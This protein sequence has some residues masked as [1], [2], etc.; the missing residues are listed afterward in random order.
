MST[1]NDAVDPNP[2]SQQ[3]NTV[4]HAF[5]NPDAS[6]ITLRTSDNFDFH[7]YKIIL[8]L[9]SPVFKDMFTLPQSQIA[10][11]D[12][13]ADGQAIIPLSEDSQTT[14]RFLKFCYP[15]VDPEL[16]TLEEVQSTLEMM[17]KYDVGDVKG[18]LVKILMSPKFVEKQPVRVFAIAYR[19]GL[20]AEARLAAKHSLGYVILS[21]FST[22]LEHITAAAYHHL[23]EYHRRCGIAAYTLGTGLRWLAKSDW[24]WFRCT[25]CIGH[26]IEWYLD[27]GTYSRTAA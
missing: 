26:S 27:D 9:A 4:H 24:V 6:D 13:F 10:P 12:A 8:S 15:S 1:N 16:E 7:V 20:E 14:E 23:L 3:A 21:S 17:S 11:Q 19:Y 22:D 5:S 25:R 2:S 18:R